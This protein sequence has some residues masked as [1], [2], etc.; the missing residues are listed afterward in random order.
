MW[1]ILVVNSLKCF[2]YKVENVKRS[3]AAKFQREKICCKSYGY[4]KS[5]DFIS[6]MVCAWWCWEIEWEKFQKIS[7]VII[8]IPLSDN[9]IDVASQHLHKKQMFFL[10]YKL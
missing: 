6:L 2:H 1:T 9:Y 5:N 8:I 10:F 3:K 7:I 4:H